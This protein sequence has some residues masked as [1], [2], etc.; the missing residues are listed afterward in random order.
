MDWTL[1]PNFTEAEFRCSH[2]GR[3]DMNLETMKR[4]QRLRHIFSKPMIVTSGYRDPSH[5]AE[6][7]KDEPGAHTMGRA[8]DIAIRGADALQLVG[9]AIAEGF[10]GVGVSQKGAS[11]FIH[12]DDVEVGLPRPMIWSY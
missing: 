8:V 4:I 10:T 3:C 1:F 12:L 9:L 11:R 7:G 5:P 6:Q 2:T